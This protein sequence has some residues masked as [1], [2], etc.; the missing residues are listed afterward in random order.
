MFKAQLNHKSPY[1]DLK[2]ESVS[3][4]AS[5]ITSFRLIPSFFITSYSM[6]RWI[7]LTINLI[8]KDTLVKEEL[9]DFRTEAIF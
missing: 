4:L 8:R 1:K 2:S 7:D 9:S 5:Q 6:S 3:L